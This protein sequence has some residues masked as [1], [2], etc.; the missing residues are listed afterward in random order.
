MIGL[1]R[2]L[3]FFCGTFVLTLAL[4]FAVSFFGAVAAAIAAVVAAAWFARRAPQKARAAM[5]AL[6]AVALAVVC[7]GI[8]QLRMTNIYGALSGETRAVTARVSD[9]DEYSGW[10]LVT[11]KVTA[12]SDSA[13]KDFEISFFTRE[14]LAQG[15][16]FTAVMAFVSGQNPYS[17]NVSMQTEVEQITGIRKRQYP[18]MAAAAA[19]RD[20]QIRSIRQ[21]LPGEEGDI[22]VAVVTGEKSRLSAELKVAFSRAGISHVLVVSGLHISLLIGLVMRMLDR[23][24]A[25]PLIRLTVLLVLTAFC[26]L[27]YGLHPS[28]LRACIMSLFSYIGVVFLRR[29]DPITAMAAAAFV[30]LAVS[31]GA[32]QDLSFLLSFG[33]CL[34]LTVVYPPVEAAIIHKFTGK[35]RWA[36]L[37]KWLVNAL[38]MTATISAVTFPLLVLFNI[39]L[40]IVAPLCNI[41]VIAAIPYLFV[42]ALLTMIPVNFVA[43]I[44]GLVA[45]VTAKLIALLARFFASFSFAAVST[46]YGWLKILLLYLAAVALILL[47][48]KEK[49]ARVALVG[50]CV[51]IV[52]LIGILSRVYFTMGDPALFLYRD[53][54][55]ILHDGNGS[56][57][58]I[59]DLSANDAAYLRADL[60]NRQMADPEAIY[61]AGNLKD[62]AEKELLRQFPESAI[63]AMR[64][65]RNP[66]ILLIDSGYRF[67]TGRFEGY[68]ETGGCSVRCG[69]LTLTF[70]RGEGT[71][72]NQPDIVLA[73]TGDGAAPEPHIGFTGQDGKTKEYPADGIL[74]V[75][76][77][78]NGLVKVVAEH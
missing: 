23:V 2:P 16:E 4:I 36:R 3:A 32:I 74:A 35:T 33:C 41:P 65:G 26:L 56:V 45:G 55:V 54:A 68:L 42:S 28:V 1:K 24:K 15:D 21:W 58:V 46:G 31:P 9:T 51:A 11:A 77:K 12:V 6:C 5:A 39:P 48:R 22:A 59:Y 19:V 70:L 72:A 64:A 63:Y 50:F 75:Y 40:S 34:A 18:L 52:V 7:W 69:D 76:F 27:Y 37:A 43:G 10:T 49:K 71:L 17:S 13:A 57:V 44:A 73:L 61:L 66:E 62:A 14:P 20:Y 38:A 78:P 29:S 60:S 47:F 30:I 53:Q 8:Q 67:R 25:K